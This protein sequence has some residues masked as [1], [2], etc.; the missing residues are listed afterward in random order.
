MDQVHGE[1]FWRLLCVG[2]AL[3]VAGCNTDALDSA[4]PLAFAQLQPDAVPPVRPSPGP[5][6]F[7]VNDSVRVKVYNEPEITGEYVVDAA[8]NVSIP[9]AGRIRAAGLTPEQLQRTIMDRLNN[10]IIHDPHVTV[11][12]S[13][14]TP[15][16][17][18]GEVKRGGEFAYRPGLTVMDAVA[19]AGGFTYRANDGKVFIRRKG[20]SVEESYPLDVPVPVHPGD[21]IRIP[22]RWF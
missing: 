8:G 5:Y 21:N 18:Q 17:I 20:S 12:V 19:E 13:A 3:A 15:F 2:L 10:G 4:G 16:Y 22:E 14:Y 6:V 7:G 9:L 11:E 1:R